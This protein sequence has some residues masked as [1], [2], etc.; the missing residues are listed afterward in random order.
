[1]PQQKVVLITGASSGFGQL[2]AQLLAQDDYR[3]FGTSRQPKAD[4]ARPYTM[5]PLDVRSDDSVAACVQQVLA[6]AGRIDV[7]VNNAGYAL[8]SLTEEATI[9]QARQQFETNFW[10][11]VRMTKAVLP[12]MRRQRDGRII[13]V[14]SLAG[15]ISVPGEGFYSATKFAIEGYSE[16]L[17]QEV[18][19]FNIRVSLIEPSYF[20]TGIDSARAEA[21]DLIPDYNPIRDRIMAVFAEGVRTGGNPVQVARLIRKVI[22]SPSPAPR[23]RVGKDAAWLPVLRAI[24][25]ARAFAWGSRKWFHIPDAV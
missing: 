3:V 13:N 9:D 6:Q 8:S 18:Y 4:P 17:A 7:L 12:T 23:C 2:T 1:M 22:A 19:P 10:G 16:A 5:L 15:L 11:T 20:R 14:S 25:P 24:L 21:S